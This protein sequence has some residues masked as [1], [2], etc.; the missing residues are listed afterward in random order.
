MSE[1]SAEANAIRQRIED[2]VEADDLMNF[3]VGGIYGEDADGDWIIGYGVSGSGNIVL[4]G[5]AVVYAGHRSEP[6]SA[7]AEAALKELRE[8]LEN[9]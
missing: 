1:F 6:F 4:K 2:A 9:C 8:Q 7:R 5:N 3:F